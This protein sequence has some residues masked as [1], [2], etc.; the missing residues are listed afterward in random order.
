MNPSDADILAG[1]LQIVLGIIVFLALIKLFS[2]NRSLK[3]LV[4]MRQVELDV[5][6]AAL[7]DWISYGKPYRRESSEPKTA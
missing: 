5:S 6:D 3:A 2:I 4:V 1:V 7:K